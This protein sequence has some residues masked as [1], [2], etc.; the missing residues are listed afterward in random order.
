MG[1]CVRQQFLV[2][3]ARILLIGHTLCTANVRHG[4]GMRGGGAPA[5]LVAGLILMLAGCTQATSRQTS[6]SPETSP[7]TAAATPTTSPAASPAASP[8]STPGGTP[9]SSPPTVSPIT[10]ALR[11]TSLPFHS[12]EVGIAYS[13]VVFGA[14]GGTPPYHWAISAG[15]LP[16]GLSLASGGQLGGTPSASGHPSLTVRATDSAGRAATA[17][18]TFTVYSALA[19]T[20]RCASLCSVEQGCTV[21][22]GFGGVSGGQGPYH[23]AITS[24]NRPDGMGVSGLTLTGSFPPPGPLGQFGLTV[25]VSDHFGAKRTVKANW[26]VFPHIAFTVSKPTCVGYGCQVQLPYTMGTP[27]GTPALAIINVVCPTVLT[28]FPPT[29]DGTPPAPLPNHLPSKGFIKGIGG[30]VVTI[31]FLN[32]NTYGNWIGTF[33]VVITDQ[34]L[35]GPGSAHCSATVK[36]TVD[37][38]TSF[39]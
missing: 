29:C 38:N 24:D 36:V 27:N 17:P 25:Q 10:P 32:P 14:T 20:Q 18:G 11:I 21:C 12:G 13:A 28:T 39:G 23:F 30:G 7:S 2:S 8:S 37:N 35:C 16:G 15:A 26:Y 34:S 6:N 31:T 4:L 19:V 1:R 5:A 33:D 3:G 22:G 9:A